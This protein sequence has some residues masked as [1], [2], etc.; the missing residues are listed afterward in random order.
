MQQPSLFDSTTG[1][2]RSCGAKIRKNLRRYA[3]GALP[4]V[5]LWTG[6]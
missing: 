4:G 5:S 1:T 6:C 2:P 3:P